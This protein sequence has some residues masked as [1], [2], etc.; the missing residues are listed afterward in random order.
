M[1]IILINLKISFWQLEK[2]DN[3]FFVL[4]MASGNAMC[5]LFLYCYSGAWATISFEKMSDVLFEL[6]WQDL[7]VVT[8]KDLIL[9]IADMQKSIHYKGFGVANLDLLTFGSVSSIVVSKNMW[10]FRQIFPFQ[11]IRAV[12]TYFMLLKTITSK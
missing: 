2:M 10:K 7:P 4:L 11:L 6:N 8:Q 9:M 12:G 5:T 3:S 1:R